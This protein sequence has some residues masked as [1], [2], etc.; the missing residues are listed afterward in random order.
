[1]RTSGKPLPFLHTLRTR[2][3]GKQSKAFSLLTNDSDYLL[4]V[5]ATSVPHF[6]LTLSIAVL[7]EYIVQTAIC[8]RVEA[9]LYV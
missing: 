7:L 2:A 9:S 4:P 5:T 1:M 3:E 8:S 6:E